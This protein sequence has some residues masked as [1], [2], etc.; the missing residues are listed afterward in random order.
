M[1]TTFE[2]TNTP[3]I[4][5]SVATNTTSPTFTT[6]G[7]QFTLSIT[8]GDSA[9]LAYAGSSYL[10]F[11]NSHSGGS[12]T[13]IIILDPV[14]T[15]QT[16]FTGNISIDVGSENGSWF[17]NGVALAVGNNVIAA[18][19]G[20]AGA[21]TFTH[22]GGTQTIV[23]NSITATVNCFLTGTHI[24][25]PQGEVAVETLQPGDRII[26]ADGA[27]TTVKWLGQQSIAPRFA[28]PEKINPIRFAAGALGDNTPT[29]DLY[30]TA[31]HAIAID[32][33][34]YNAGALVNGSTI[35]QV[36]D[37][38]LDGFTYWHVE[39]DCHEL[40][41]AE[42]VASESYL[43]AD[44]QAGFDNAVERDSTA[45]IPE[46]DLPRITAA[47]LVPEQLC[48]RLQDQSDIKSNSRAA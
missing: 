17:A 37:M 26:T 34:L 5:L 20:G 46:M 11:T 43:D 27:E 33:V 31:D 24:A 39:T 45:P 1:S 23:I 40:I 48:T 12:L 47:R 35:S 29:R 19:A 3:E 9:N 30:L 25:T 36:R 4:S 10:S 44:W 41:L 2:F 18:G 21:I 16:K 28:R 7:V 32:G 42:G 14:G 15:G 38:P 8:N 13:D 22:S 6:N